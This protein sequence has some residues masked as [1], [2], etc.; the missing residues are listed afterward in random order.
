MKALLWASLVTSTFGATHNDEQYSPP[1]YPSPWAK[2]EG[3]WAD[4]HQKALDF[5][6]QLTLAEKVNLTTGNGWMQH[7][8]V[9]ETGSV[10]RLGFDGICFQDGPLGIRFAHYVSSF[11]AGINVA[12]TWDRKLAYTRGQAMGKEFSDKG[13]DVQLGPV[14]GPIGR[15]PE[16]GRNWEGF[17]PDP[18]L[19][20]VFTAET[21]RGMQDA[22]VITSLKHFIGNEQE[23]FRIVREANGYGFNISESA[24][25]QIDDKTMHELYLWPFADAVRAGVGSIM[26]SY[27]QINNSYGCANS[28][29][30]NSLLKNE[31]D[32][33][34]FVVTDWGAHGTGVASAFAGLDVS[35]PG[36][37]DLGSGFS[38]WG[39]NLT[40][41]VLNGTVPEWRLD[42]M[43]V[44]LMSAYYKVGRDKLRVPVNF[45]SWTKHTYG[46]EHA[47]VGPQHGYDIVNQHVDVH[48]GQSALIR[49]IGAESTVLLKNNGVL[50]LSGT[51]KLTAIIGEDAGPNAW[52]ANG[53]EDRSCDNGTLATGWGSGTADY[54]YLIT[55]ADA[56]QRT[57][58]DKGDGLVDLVTHNW[59]YDK[60]QQLA[61]QASVA[62]VFVNADAGEGFLAVDGNIGD[63][64][65]LTLWKNGEEV[66]RQTASVC[67][68]TV[69]V[70]HTVGPVL[71]NSW[72]DHEN[73]KAIL[74]A[75]LPGQESGNAIADIL[76]GQV[77][78]GAKSP[79]T[80]GKDRESY[81]APLLYKQNN[82]N[83]APQI[84]FT[85]G[86]FID[87][88][89]FDKT[90][91]TPIYE[92]GHGLSYTTFSY[93]DLQIQKLDAAPYK[94]TTG[95]TSPASSPSNSSKTWSEYLFPESIRKVP[96]YIYPYLNSTDPKEASADRHYG[97]PT[98]Q[99]IPAGATNSSAQPLH[100][101]GGAPGGN[102]GL[103]EEVYKVTATITNT[104]TRPGDEVVQVYLSLGGPDDPQI[105]LRGFDKIA[106]ET[107][108]TKTFSAVLTRRDISNW[109]PVTQDWVVSEYPKTVFVGSSS[110]KLHLNAAL[111]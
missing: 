89:A 19:T 26:C 21:V 106:L 37:T 91:T 81:G 45:N 105:V 1:F 31:L 68:N 4:A 104:G 35:M 62:L 12:A 72:Y 28:Y 39:G 71:I 74:W 32:F 78:P 109:D 24:S 65:N 41:A 79:F 54:P 33:Q 84:D 44:R 56:I 2:G 98:D 9:G 46:A 92:F 99:Y 96:L 10:P 25:T 67:N 16:G 34:G 58:L 14:S 42:D 59:A 3:G 77:N 29:T 90:N 80:W 101:A 55:P 108:Q 36:D 11:P 102:A 53:C 49:K 6:S 82:G 97:L 13:A 60:I 83:E 76:Y 100:P 43:A 73:I 95:Y 51:E 61:S 57:I 75:G 20:G 48:R 88:R 93:S 69:V 87:Y 38:Y 86:V 17:S 30:M 50:P 103:W 70:M 22:G 110:R 8:C 27:Q 5:V 52:G 47:M 63:R 23:H 7:H 15:S 94:P 64:N 18:V 107:G 66:I 111:P 85:E 40:I